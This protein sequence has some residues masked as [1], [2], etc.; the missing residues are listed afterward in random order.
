MV[1]A[2]AHYLVIIDQVCTTYSPLKLF[3]WPARAFSIVENAEKVRPLISNFHSKIPS[4]LQR[5][6]YIEMKQTSAARGKLMLIIIIIWPFE[7][8]EL[9]RHA[10][11]YGF[12]RV[13][14]YMLHSEFIPAL[15][16]RRDLPAFYHRVYRYTR[17]ITETVSIDIILKLTVW[18][19]S[20]SHF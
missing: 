1:C 5:K 19:E 8:S 7:L 15:G 11:G 10:I 6:L 2:V 13:N 9:C 17:L 4:I 3:L 20:Q 18:V 16:T 14:T 12:I